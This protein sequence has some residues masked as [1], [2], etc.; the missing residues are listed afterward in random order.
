[1]RSIYVGAHDIAAGK[2][3]TLR[4]PTYRK[5]YEKAYRMDLKR[6]GGELSLEKANKRLQ[7]LIALRKL[8]LKRRMN[9]RPLPKDVLLSIAS[10][11]CTPEQVGME[12]VL[13][14]PRELG[15]IAEILYAEKLP[16][17]RFWIRFKEYFIAALPDGIALDYVYEFKATTKAGRDLAVLRDRARVQ[18]VLYAYAFKRTNIRVQIARLQIPKEAFPIKVGDLPKPDVETISKPAT[19]EEA[20]TILS[21]FDTAFR[22]NNPD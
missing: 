9:K 11:L 18:A 14:D 22:K 10:F 8:G 6:Y 7:G 13:A 5:R 21:K 16:T 1:M 19:E 20:L 17:T 15:Q 12:L 3:G 2:I 4:N